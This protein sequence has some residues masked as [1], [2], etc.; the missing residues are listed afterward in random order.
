MNLT[1]TSR[2]LAA[3]FIIRDDTFVSS[4][5]NILI[6]I[7]KQ[8]I[9]ALADD[10]YTRVDIPPG[11]Y[12]FKAA[13]T[14]EDF[15]DP[16]YK[17]TKKRTY[18]IKPNVVNII[19]FLGG[20][21]FNLA[22]NMLYG[23]PQLK[24]YLSSDYQV[25]YQAIIRNAPTV[26]ADKKVVKQSTPA[27]MAKVAKN[28]ASSSQFTSLLSSAKCKLTNPDWAYTGSKCKNG[29]AHGNGSAVDRSG[30]KFIGSFVAGKRVKGEIHQSGN[31][32]F[33]GSL[34]ADKP[35]GEAICYYEGEYEEC[36][37]FKGKRIDTLYKI[38]KENAKMKE[39]MTQLRQASPGSASQENGISDYAIDALEKEAADRAANFIFDSL[40]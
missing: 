18:L 28:K 33:S 15:N 21:T 29:K 27:H 5:V 26:K 31:M 11:R 7:D 22:N 30:L 19:R 3:V 1:P 25:P 37:F 14:E 12:I 8:K 23:K 38:R 6:G 34:L 2:D 36:R 35:N 20:N 17:Y 16:N 9:I 39:E 10:S 13:I 32:I 40:F 24:R 4:G